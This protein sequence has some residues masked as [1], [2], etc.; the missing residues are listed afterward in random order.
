MNKAEL[1]KSMASKAN[2][3]QKDCLA[4]YEAFVSSIETAMENG[5]KVS[6]NGFGTYGIKTIKARTGRNPKT[7]EIVSVAEKYYPTFK[8]APSVKKSVNSVTIDV[9]G[10]E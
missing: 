8:F 7:G 5:D 4:V 10:A 2:M 9:G 3:T 1:I 6:L